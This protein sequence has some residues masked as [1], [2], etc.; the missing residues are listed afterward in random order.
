M[1]HSNTRPLEWFGR[2]DVPVIGFAKVLLPPVEGGVDDTL[3]IRK[4]KGCV[5]DLINSNARPLGGWGSGGT[6]DR[7]QTISARKRID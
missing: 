3:P 4:P 7:I 2:L 5:A 6:E 1:F